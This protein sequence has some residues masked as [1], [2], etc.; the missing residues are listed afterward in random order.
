MVDH[1]DSEIAIAATPGNQVVNIRPSKPPTAFV[2]QGREFLFPIGS[3][4]IPADDADLL[5]LA[6]SGINIV[7]C[8]DRA[9]LDRAEKFGL[10]GWLPLPVHQGATPELRKQIQA[11]VD[12]PALAVWEGPDEIVWNFTAYSGLL[13]SA[14]IK[15][16]DWYEQRSNAIEYSE[17][18]ALEILPKMREGI[19]LVK[20]IDPQNRP[21]WMNE[22]A[23][24][25]LRYVR[26]YANFV[27]A[28]GCDYYPVRGS[29]FDLR[30]ISKMVDRW[31][32]VGRGKP[33]WMVL[34]AFSW[35]K[36]NPE[37][38]LRYPHF[39]E[40]RYMAYATIAHGGQGVFYWGSFSIDDPE[41][42][43]S[44][45]AVATELA[46]LQPFL[47]AQPLPDV[48]MKHRDD[49]GANTFRQKY[50]SSFHFTINSG[51]RILTAIWQE[52]R[53]CAKNLYCFGRR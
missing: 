16:E 15:K 49:K 1:P 51:I 8:G 43:K 2:R 23:D 14:G 31:H 29:D 10:Q 46:M 28:I 39:N 22:A 4:D 13:K 21:F 26:G 3:Y 27:D 41:F 17:S 35:H 36:L 20:S 30:S 48:G 45:Y 40:S 34:Q 6:N 19:A 18:Q 25:D 7:R 24:S 42:Q 38:G 32:A 33:V 47:T 37:R 9:S 12:H 53:N 11:V 52:L 44:I 5:E 50:R